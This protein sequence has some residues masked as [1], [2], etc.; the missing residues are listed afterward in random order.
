MRNL[1]SL[2]AASLLAALTTFLPPLS[3][4]TPS[5]SELDSLREQIR[6][7]DQ[8]LRVLERNQEIK[9]EAAAAAA[10]QQPKITFTDKGIGFASADGNN[11]LKLH[12]LVQA[13]S[14]WFFGGES[15]PNNNDAFLIRRARLIFEGAFAKNYEYLIVPEFGGNSGSSA[16]SNVTLLDAYINVNLRPEFQVRAGRFREPVG[17]EQLQSDAV[18][19]FAERSI[20]SQFVPNRDIGMQLTGDLFNGTL[21]YAAGAFNGVPDGTSNG[22]NTDIN[23]DKNYAARL[24][25]QPFKNDKD[26][27]LAGL[28]FGIAGSI[29][30]ENNNVGALTGGYK[31]DAQQTWFSYSAGVVAN[32]SV[33]RISPQAYYYNG[34]LGLMAE[35]VVSS[36][37]VRNATGVNQK[38]LENK[39]WQVSAGY[40]LTGEDAGYKGVTPSTNFSFSDGTWGAFEVVARL[41][42]ADIDDGAFAGPSA[43]RIASI[44]SSA[45]AATAY[46]L[47]LNWYL[48]KT[49]RASFD[50]FHTKF[51]LASGAAPAS[52]AVVAHDENA[53]VTRLQ[54]SF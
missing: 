27:V 22:S 24:F 4:Q 46:G 18:A 3:A 45:T 40:V 19:F 13:D 36:V 52:T 7:L 32:G 8:K 12:G 6:L 17:L 30:K 34:P 39:A 31:T 50:Y 29:G 38:Q 2:G 54:L 16:S 35:Y 43:T 25:A 48:S 20:V 5:N 21:S 41:E 26:S 49:V 53:F 1:K 42:H 9:D 37:E 44:N 51:D 11:Y 23:N 33:S 14:R 47:G 15:G 10:K 28:G